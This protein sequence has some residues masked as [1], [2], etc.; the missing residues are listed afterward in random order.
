MPQGE[1]IIKIVDG[2]YLPFY[3]KGT[4]WKQNTKWTQNLGPTRKTKKQHFDG[5]PISRSLSPSL[6]DVLFIFLLR[7]LDMVLATERWVHHFFLPSLFHWKSFFYSVRTLFLTEEKINKTEN[8]KVS[9]V[10]QGKVK[11]RQASMPAN[12][13]CPLCASVSLRCLTNS[14]C[15]PGQCDGRRLHGPQS[16]VFV[17]TS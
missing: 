4:S 14:I 6:T 15:R 1:K 10:I 11:P 16:P 13:K 8:T 3:Q 2:I 5:H 9:S 12:C 17:S 7:Q